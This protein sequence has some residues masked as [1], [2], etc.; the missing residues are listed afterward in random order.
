MLYLPGDFIHTGGFC[1]GRKVR[2]DFSNEHV[3]FYI[4]DG[5]NTNM[6]AD[7]LDNRNHN[8]HKPKYVPEPQLL[9]CI[10]TRL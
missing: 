2:N 3:H 7:A 5:N 10:K 4:C 6:L 9:S 1:F 8:K